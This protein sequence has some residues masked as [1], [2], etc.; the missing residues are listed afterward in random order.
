ML[1]LYRYAIHRRRLTHCFIY[2][3]ISGVVDHV[4]IGF[5]TCAD[6]SHSVGVCTNMLNALQS[7]SAVSGYYGQIPAPSS[8]LTVVVV[9]TE[10]HAVY[11]ALPEPDTSCASMPCLNGG[12]TRVRCTGC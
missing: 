6:E 5:D 11:T 8:T 9:D 1:V 10:L 7:Y 12:K 2:F 4:E 3:C